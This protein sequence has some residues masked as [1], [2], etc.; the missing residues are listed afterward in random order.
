VIEKQD[1]LRVLLEVVPSKSLLAAVDADDDLAGNPH[2]AQ[3]LSQAGMEVD[4]SWPALELGPPR[5]AVGSLEAVVAGRPRLRRI[6]DGVNLVGDVVNRVGDAL[7]FV[8]AQVPPW[9]PERRTMLFRA[10]LPPDERAALR[11]LSVAD[12]QTRI[13]GVFND[14]AVAI[15]HRRLS[16]EP[17]GTVEQVEALMSCAW[18]HEHS[19]TGEGVSVAVVDS[20]INL[21]YLAGRGRRHVL[22]AGLSHVPKWA[23][24]E[25]GQFPVGHGTL[26]AFQVGIAAPD[27]T[28]LDH[29]VLGRSY[30]D[31]DE[32]LIKAWLSDIEPGYVALHRYLS[33]QE[34]SERRLVVTN[35]WAMIDPDW[36]FPTAHIENFSDNA[37]HPFNRMVRALVRAG[38]DVLFAAGNCGREDPV[39][40]CGFTSQPICGANSMP[41]VITV[42]A[43]DVDGVRL[44]YS[45]Q[46]PGRIDGGFEKPDLSGY[47]HYH[48]SGVEPA[49]WGTST[50]CPGVAGVVAAVRSRYSAAELPPLELKQLVLRSAR[51]AADGHNPD[52]GYGVIDPRALLE[53][54]LRAEAA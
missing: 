9:T 42:A 3:A 7:P 12:E 39:R 18:L 5:T 38:A 51:G 50:A 19:F 21:D 46:G 13:F 29:A 30:E 53:E 37:R 27:A 16:T 6:A 48:G 47:S 52:T 11:A 8:D 44:G 10:L 23:D 40:W 54:L 24:H 43:V 17:F 35:S 4:P 15:A 26:A 36:D 49:D 25:P 41:D 45:S 20:G 34:P 31:D 22:D 1:R 14:P 32:P 2:A 28:L 33:E